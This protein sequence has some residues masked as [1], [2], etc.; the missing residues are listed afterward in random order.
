MLSSKHPSY[1]YSSFTPLGPAPLAPFSYEKQRRDGVLQ[2]VM[3][4]PNIL[5]PT[6][7]YCTRP[8]EKIANVAAKTVGDETV[9]SPCMLHE[10]P[11]T[12]GVMSIM[13]TPGLAGEIC[14]EVMLDSPSVVPLHSVGFEMASPDV[15]G[16][17]DGGWSC[18]M[19]TTMKP[20]K[21]PLIVTRKKK[22]LCC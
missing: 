18:N 8:A 22:S 17:R 15:V 9:S 10:P 21:V 19:L 3:T 7:G 12:P 16:N 2:K 4:A 11:Q 14:I 1:G 5:A 20:T 6:D 13:P